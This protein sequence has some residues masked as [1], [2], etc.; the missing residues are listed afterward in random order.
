M[1][2][3]DIISDMKEERRTK[4]AEYIKKHGDVSM[5]ELKSEFK[6]SMNT[7]RADIASLVESRIITKVYGGVKYRNPDIFEVSASEERLNIHNEVKSNIARLAASLIE[8]GDIIYI[9]YGTTTRQMIDA[10]TEKKDLIVVTPSF[11]VMA[12]LINIPTIK[13]VVLPGEF[14]RLASGVISEN[15]IRDLKNY[16]FSKAFMACTGVDANLK[17]TTTSYYQRKI[18]Q[19]A[20]S[21]A[22]KTYLL[23]DA[24][25][26]NSPGLLNYCDLGSFDA[27]ITNSE[28]PEPVLKK[29]RQENIKV[30]IAK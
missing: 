2:I 9:D 28:V 23:V 18:K 10:I 12:K 17:V 25:K 6:V 3:R 22:K 15:T 24:S 14:D 13:L 26:Y 21:Q 20:M 16:R 5:K 27:V 4:I 11:F 8:D 29:I 19:T 7:I 1:R 30:L